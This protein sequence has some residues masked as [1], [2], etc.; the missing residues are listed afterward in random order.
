MV[1]YPHGIVLS[2]AAYYF[3]Q[4]AAVPVVPHVALDSIHH[5]VKPHNNALRNS[6]IEEETSYQPPPSCS[7]PCHALL[8]NLAKCEDDSCVCSQ[9]GMNSF[10]E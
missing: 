8:E 10:I 1:A 2:L 6:S 5:V 4:V 7:A 9:D 3:A